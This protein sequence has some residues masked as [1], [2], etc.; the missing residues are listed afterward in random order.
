MVEH[1][2]T[3]IKTRCSLLN[4]HQREDYIQ[5]LIIQLLN[6]ETYIYIWY[7][8][9]TYI[10][11]IFKKNRYRN[12][13]K[14]AHKETRSH[15][16]AWQLSGSPTWWRCQA[17][18]G[19]NLKAL[20]LP[21]KLGFLRYNNMV[22]KSPVRIGQREVKLLTPILFLENITNIRI[23]HRCF[24]TF[25][26][27]GGSQHLPKKNQIFIWHW[28]LGRSRQSSNDSFWQGYWG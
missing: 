16:F 22:V 11:Y 2:F 17:P 15:A 8:P 4:D 7:N 26:S 23:F 6:K 19:L 3:L 27:D 20:K 1:Q 12:R 28:T 13:K 9:T 18:W 5:Q 14:D 10:L 21:T 25:R 24:P